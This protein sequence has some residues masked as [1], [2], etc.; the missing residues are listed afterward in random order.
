MKLGILDQS[1]VRYNATVPEALQETIE[2]ARLVENLGYSRF[3]ISEH[4]NSPSIAGS[5]P[6]VLLARLAAETQTIRMGSGGIMLPNHSSFKVAE[7][8][9][10]LEALYPGRIDLGMGRAPGGDRV[11]AALLNP[12]NQFSE[13]DY[14]KQLD[15]LNLFFR[16][17]AKTNNGS[18]KAIP[19]APTVPQQWIL[20]SSGGSARIAAKKGLG[21][22]VA[23]FI[24]GNVTPAVVEN[25]RAAF[26]PSENFEKPATFMSVFV[27]C[28]KTEKRAAFL[29]KYV[30]YLLL[31]IGKGNFGRHPNPED[32]ENYSFSAYEQHQLEANSGRVVSGTQEEVKSELSQ[33]ARDFDLDELMLT[34]IAPEKEWRLESFSLIAEAFDLKPKSEA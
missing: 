33:L 34:T 27:V 4:H 18:I 20:S 1:I 15:Y 14:I 10:M 5:T 9:R 22:S 17:L 21:L 28:A 13:A 24:N 32:V 26:E 19:Q 8:F 31:Q 16:D 29:R 30:D 6:E 7:N 25:Y 23:K 2:T 12:S 3:W 11:S